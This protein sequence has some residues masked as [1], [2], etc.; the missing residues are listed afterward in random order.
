[1]QL[2]GARGEQALQ[3]EPERLAL[4]LLRVG[5]AD[6]RDRIGVGETGL[7]ERQTP[8]ELRAVD[9]VGGGGNSISGAAR[10]RE[11]PLEGEVVDAHH[12]GRAGATRKARVDRCESG[13]PVVAVEHLRGATRADSIRRRAARRRARAAR[14]AARCRASRGPS[15]ILVRAAVAIVERRA[16]DEPGRHAAR[17]RCLE[18][19]RGREARGRREARELAALPGGRG[20]HRAV[21]GQQHVHVEPARLQRRG[22]RRAHVAEAA[23]LDPRGALGR[24]EQDVASGRASSA[25]GRIAAMSRRLVLC[26]DIGGTKTLLAIA[27]ARRRPVRHGLRAA[28]RRPRLRRVRRPRQ[29]LPRRSADARRRRVPRRRGSGRGSS[30]RRHELPLADRRRCARDRPRRAGRARERLCRGGARDRRPPAGG[31]CDAPGRR[32]RAARAA[33]RDRRRHGARRRLPRVA[34]RPLRCDRRRGRACRVRTGGRTAGG[35]VAGASCRVRA[36]G[37]RAD[38]LGPRARAHPRLPAGGARGGARAGRDRVQRR[39]PSPARPSTSSSNALARW[40]A[41]MR[42]RSSPAAV[43][44]SPAGLRRRSCRSSGAARFSRRLAQRALT[45]DSCRVSRC[46]WW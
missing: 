17:Q 16:V 25:A 20:E 43:S 6:G 4:D 34:E 2:A 24:G 33:G 21:G 7:Q 5:R 30:R 12:R 15:R 42:S 37:R 29:R 40:R 38:R 3:P 36:R 46:A 1:M 27:R 32:A 22:Q 14:T 45:R 31:R 18:Q 39:S 19:P 28:L 26:G 10:G 44:F 35:A 11:Q 9:R 23:G 8:V 41:T 13:L